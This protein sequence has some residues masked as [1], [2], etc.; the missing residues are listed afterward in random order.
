MSAN[1]RKAP[2]TVITMGALKP[3]P[4]RRLEIPDGGSRGLLL[5]VHPTG[6]KTWI[7]RFRRAGGKMAKMTLGPVDHGPGVAD[8]KIGGPLTL[9]AARRLAAEVGHKRA[10]GIDPIGER[11]AAKTARREAAIASVATRYGAL[12]REFV[13]DYARKKQRRWR[14]T[15]RLLGLRPAGGGLQPIE[16]GLAERWAARPVGEITGREIVLVLKECRTK[17]PPGLTRRRPAGLETEGMS[18]A[19]LTTLSRY[20]SWCVSQHVIER[21]P[22]AGLRRPAAPASR[23]RT[24]D[25][26]EVVAFWAATDRL[27]PP[28]GPALR[29]LLLTGQRLREIT[30]LAASEISALD[31]Q[32]AKLT[33]GADR[34]K[35]KRAHFVPLAPMA[36]ETLS[37]VPR[38]AGCP[39]VFSTNGRTPVSGWSKVKQR[40]DVLMEAE[41][42]HALK[43]WRLHDLRRTC[44]A[45]MAR[46]GVNI[47][48]TEKLLNHAGGVSGGIVAI[49]QRHDYEPERRAAL[50]AYER[51]LRGLLD[52]T[53]GDNIVPLAGARNNGR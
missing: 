52:G 11:E 2:L 53:D 4:T 25:D 13:E 23:E 16:N 51:Y 47:V 43:P 5:L 6:R 9:A 27:G 34:T 44:A 46:I 17:A 40:L 42:G 28:F 50:E 20:F 38:L 15:A 37:S 12:A 41:M 19:M 1:R 45:T 31:C 10:Q 35:N 48:V 8:P 7:M 36:R 30:D 49:Y 18:R 22:C 33:L 14:E 3:D 39:Y 21:S 32:N 24:L 26:A 29:L